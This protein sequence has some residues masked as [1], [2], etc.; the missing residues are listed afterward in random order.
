MQLTQIDI[1]NYKSITSPVSIEF[2]EGEVVTLIGKNGS[3]KTNILEALR[4]T[5]SKN[6]YRNNQLP[7]PNATF[8]FS[9]TDDERKRYF[10]DI[11]LNEND[12]TIEVAYNGN[13]PN[14]RVIK[15]PA[16]N[17]CVKEFRNEASKIL[18]AFK[19][20]ADSYIEN[21]R[22]LEVEN[23]SDFLVYLGVECQNQKGS[24]TQLEKNLIDNI[25][26]QLD[27]QT[28][29]IEQLLNMFADDT[30]QLTDN[31]T[32]LAHPVALWPISQCSIQEQKIQI[33]PII[34]KSLNLS[35]TQVKAANIKLNKEIK[36]INNKLKDSHQQ[37]QEQIKKF[38]ALK[39][40]IAATFAKQDDLRHELQEKTET[41]RKLFMQD[42][43]NAVFRNCY[44]LDN[45]NTLFFASNQYNDYSRQQ[46]QSEYFGARNPI[47]E[48]FHNFLYKKG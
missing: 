12:G 18:Y 23:T 28:E 20:A 37:I 7:R 6:H 24:L 38:E 27:Q 43:S 22:K 47:F 17:I 33:S 4:Q 16:V 29:E 46:I 44:F 25:K 31:Y 36:T 19:N 48:A 11:E 39:K 35:A 41:N 13:E 15:S 30:F 26:Q 8:Y 32:S 42:L 10:Q 14:V 21:L 3:G 45:E 1:L 2:K 9:L 40:R 5:L 34:A